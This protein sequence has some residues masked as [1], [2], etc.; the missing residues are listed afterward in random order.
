MGPM[1]EGGFIVEPPVEGVGGGDEAGGG[2]GELAG[3]G[4]DCTG[5]GEL[6]GGEG[7]LTTGA[8]VCVFVPCALELP[9]F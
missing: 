2:G 3:G 6:A 1:F 4:G 8:D 7:G 9:V 5:G